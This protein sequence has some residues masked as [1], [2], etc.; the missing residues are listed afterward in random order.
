MKARDYLIYDLIFISVIILL[1]LGG[2]WADHI[3]HSH[4]GQP[5]V[6]SGGK[7]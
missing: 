1:A 7:R 2:G 5:S 4:N 6:F 3:G